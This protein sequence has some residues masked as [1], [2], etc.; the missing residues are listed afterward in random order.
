MPCTGCGGPCPNETEQGAA[1]ISALTSIL[2]VAEEKERDYDVEKLISQI[3]D[4]LGTF[5]RYSLPA[6]IL[7]RR[8]MK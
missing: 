5:Y 2:G 1:M 6:S 4:P 8:I 7:R 3:K